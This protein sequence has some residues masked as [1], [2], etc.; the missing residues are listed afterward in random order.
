MQQ[1]QKPS[2]SRQLLLLL[3]LS[4]LFLLPL[5]IHPQALIYPTYAPHSDLMTIHW[6]KATLQAQSLRA[7]GQWPLWTPRILSGMPLLANPLAMCFYPPVLLFL[8]LPAGIAFNLLWIFHFWL[9]AAGAYLWLRRAVNLSAPASSLGALTFAFTAKMAAHMAAGHV[10]VIAAAAWLPWALYLADQALTRGRLRGALLAGAALALQAATHSQIFLYTAYLLLIYGLVSLALG[11]NGK[12]IKRSLLMLLIFVTAALLGAAQLLP[13]A[14]MAPYSNRVLGAG[15]ASSHALTPIQLLVSLLLPTGQG[16]HES[17]LYLGLTPLLLIPFTWM[18]RRGWRVTFCAVLALFALIFALGDSTPLYPL[19]RRLPG[20]TY[21]R[22]PARL[23]FLLA[24]AVATLAAAGFDALASVS[25]SAALRRRWP[26]AAVGIAATG[27]SAGLGF[28]LI[29]GVGSRA[30]WGLALFPLLGAGLISARRSLESRRALF[31]SIAWGALILFDLWSFDGTLWRAVSPQD[32]FAPGA[33]AAAWLEAQ[34]G[35]FRVYSPGYAIEQQVAAEHGL[36]LADGVEPVHLAAYDRYTGLATG[37]PVE[38]FSVTVPPFPDEKNLSQAHRD[39]IPN[40]KL[41]GLLNVRYLVAAFDIRGVEL[42]ERARFGEI[43]VFENQQALPRAF[44]VGEVE[45]VRD[46]AESL[47]RLPEID[48]RRTA[49]VEKGPS[50]NDGVAFQEA[51]VLLYTPNRIELEVNLSAPGFLVL[52]E[53]W[54]PGWQAT[55]NDRP[56][57][58]YKADHI[59]R[60]LYLERGAHRVAFTYRPLSLR[61]GGVISGVS[62]L[63]LIAYLTWI[64]VRARRS[65]S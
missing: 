27:L 14:E 65:A 42:I 36:E 33:E 31:L 4:G 52:S 18:R 25:W 53:V 56:L 59:L 48:P 26:L 15:E 16:G 23:G 64:A 13:L 5:L 47:A 62:A 35:R 24:L 40:L 1:P 51:P 11:K 63:A 7:H 22:T 49:L 55:D 57:P 19:L 3:I 20:L 21:T 54:Y 50:F 8:F 32:A 10:T 39:A 46:E 34:P 12:R 45:P 28:M 17:V 6:P 38:G 60:G 61:V 29:S 43:R 41:L 37:V 9:A 44:V 30:Y 2:D 58:I